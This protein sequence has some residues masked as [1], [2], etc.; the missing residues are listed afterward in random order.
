M[1]SKNLVTQKHVISGDYLTHLRN[2]AVEQNVPMDALMVG[3]SLTPQELLDPPQFV[4]DTDFNTVSTN[5][6]SQLKQPFL[7]AVELAKGM[8]FSL[9]GA[10]GVAIQGAKNIDQML[11]LAQKYYRSRASSRQLVLER[12]SGYLHVIPESQY[13]HRSPCLALAVLFSFKQ[14]IYHKLQQYKLE[15]ECHINLGSSRPSYI[16]D[17]WQAS[18]SVSFNAQRDELLVPESWLSLPVEAID[19]NFARI[20]EL[21]CVETL[22]SLTP[23]DVKTIVTDLL[24]SGPTNMLNIKTVAHELCMS[25]S[26]L[27]RR[28]KEEGLTFK[29]LKQDIITSEAKKLLQQGCK[30]ED[31][32]ESL[33]FNDA[34]SFS[35]S[36]KATVGQTPGEYK[37]R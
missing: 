37:R 2:F 16:S 33:G 17:E 21:Q 27:Q 26:S 34:S 30:V 19:F 12:Q 31:I 15:G 36:F 29:A 25:P 11:M 1:L 5:L 20:A 24:K 32:A 28:L 10:L 18:F 9:H 23:N 4:D 7:K 8:S 14:Q 35:K 6:F 22:A 13:L 3:V